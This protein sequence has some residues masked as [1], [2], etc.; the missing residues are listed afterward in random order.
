MS[1]RSGKQEQME[2]NHMFKK[3]LNLEKRSGNVHLASINSNLECFSSSSNLQNE[4]QEKR[5]LG[6]LESVKTPDGSEDQ[7]QCCDFV[8]VEHGEMPDV[9]VGKMDKPFE[10]KEDILDKNTKPMS[11]TLTIKTGIPQEN[12]SMSHGYSISRSKAR[13]VSTLSTQNLDPPQ[14]NECQNEGKEDEKQGSGTLATEIIESQ[15]TLT[16]NKSRQEHQV[17]KS[18]NTLEMKNQ[19]FH[20][21]CTTEK[22][23][24]QC[25]PEN[26]T[27][28]ENTNKE[29][30]QASNVVENTSDKQGETKDNK[31][32]NSF[33]PRSNEKNLN[34]SGET[35]TNER[36]KTEYTSSER[37]SKEVQ[38]IFND[39]FM[40]LS[41][42]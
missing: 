21:R 8:I 29:G 4:D 1:K 32:L 25:Q 12:G 26:K 15:S 42:Y 33:A 27:N 2:G 14:D 34:D 6:S 10:E 7:A 23:Q 13:V 20:Y 19:T 31:Q 35:F 18:Y 41:Y 28:E 36:K 30:P 22:G 37:N 40:I 39:L 17:V 16:K 9:G 24:S 5:I 11:D 3:P 38:I